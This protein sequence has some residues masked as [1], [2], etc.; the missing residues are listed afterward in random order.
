VTRPVLQYQEGERVATAAELD[1]WAVP[2]GDDEREQILAL[3]RWFTARYPT[4]AA[5]LAYVR[6]AYQRWQHLRATT[7]AER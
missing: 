1:A 7:N 6:R 2:I 4:P 3:I 5:R